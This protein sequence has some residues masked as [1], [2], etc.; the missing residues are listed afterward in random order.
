VLLDFVYS[1]RSRA[2]TVVHITHKAPD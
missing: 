2:K 1:I